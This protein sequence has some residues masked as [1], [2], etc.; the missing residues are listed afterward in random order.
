MARSRSGLVFL[1]ALALE[2]G[3]AALAWI[4]VFKQDVV[5]FISAYLLISLFYM[6]CCFRITSTRGSLLGPSFVKWIWIFGL[7]FRLTVIGLD[8]GLSEDLYRYRWQGKLQAAGGNPYT[9]TPQNPRWDHL[10][11]STWPEVTRKDLPSVYGP[12]LEGLHAGW[13]HVANILTENEIDQAWWFKIPFAF[14]ELGVAFTLAR[15]LAAMGLPAAYLL[16]YLWSPLVVVEFWAQGHND[17]LVVWLLLLA[18]LA[19]T[20]NRWTWAFAWLT[21]SALT[22]FWPALLFPFFLLRREE[23]RWVFRWKPALIAIPVAAAVCL[24]YLKGIANVH[25]LLQGFL[26]GWRNNDSLYGLIYAA[27]G[28]NFDDGTVMVTRL[29]ALSLAALWSLQLPLVKAAKWVVVILIFLSANC[30]P[31]YLSWLLPFLAIYPGAPLLLWTAL[32]VLAYH[33]LIGYEIL[34]VWQDSDTF[35]ALEYLPVYGM[36]LGRALVT[37]LPGLFARGGQQRRDPSVN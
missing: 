21:L 11:D 7:L 3:F 5:G 28:E 4:G 27:V 25:E 15:L 2:A 18:L 19:A 9:E 16:L 20:R 33:I 31:W 29:L 8:P 17:T 13:Y 12:L 34:G 23:G 37:R 10:R 1:L 35:R 14:C 32:V 24:P 6:F 30:F 36:L 22:K 26:G